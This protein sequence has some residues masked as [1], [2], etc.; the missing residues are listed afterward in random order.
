MRPGLKIQDSGRLSLKYT[1]QSLFAAKKKKM[2]I[3]NT[4]C[5]LMF[6]ATAVVSSKSCITTRQGDG[7]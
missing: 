6:Q 7:N 5:L 2:Y 1:K 4:N 3:G